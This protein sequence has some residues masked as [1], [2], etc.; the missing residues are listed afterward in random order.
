MTTAPCRRGRTLRA[1]SLRRRSPHRF[2][3]AV[4]NVGPRCDVRIRS[5]WLV[6]L[7]RVRRCQCDELAS[8]GAPRR[9]GPCGSR[10]RVLLWTDEELTSRI[11]LE[12]VQHITTAV[13]PGPKAHPNGCLLLRPPED[14]LPPPA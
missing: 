6:G 2:C 7:R 11:A 12:P 4:A 5:G 1:Q 9:L 8:S 10:R 13:P 14:P 3:A